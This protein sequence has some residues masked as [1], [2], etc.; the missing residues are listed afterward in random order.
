M[1]ETT[2]I[3]R[4][5]DSGTEDGF[6]IFQKTD[7]AAASFSHGYDHSSTSFKLGTGT[8]FG[9]DGTTEALLLTKAGALTTGSTTKTGTDAAGL[10]TTIHGGQSTGDEAGGSIIFRTAPAGGSGSSANSLATA[11]TIDSTKKVTLAGSLE[12]NGA[13]ADINA[14]GALTLDSSAGSI[15]MGAALADGQT[16]SLG[17][18]SAT[19]MI[20][21]PHGTAGSEKI[22]LT[23]TSGTA[24]DAISI[25]S[26]AGSIDI[27]AGGNITMDSNSFSIDAAGDA[28]NITLVTDGDAEDLTIAVTG[29][30][31]SSLVLSSTGTGADALQVTASAGGMDITSAGVMDITT[32]GGNS[33]I[34]IDPNGSG[35]L[36]LGSADNTSVTMDALALTLTSVNALTLT[37]GTATIA[38]GGTGDTT[39]SGATTVDLD[40]SGAMSLNSTGGAISIGNDDIN[41]AIN[42][43]T[44]G[45]RTINVATGAFADTVNIGNATGATAVNLT[46]GT[47]GIALASTG[48]GDITINSDDTM[49][50][51]ADGVLELNSSAG[52]ISIG[53]DA[54]AQA[55][56]VG[57]GAA[58]RTIT[59]GNDASAKVDV[60]ALIIELDSAGTIVTDSVTSTAI[61][62]GSTMSLTS[63]T[64]MTLSSGGTLAIDTGGTDAINFGTEAA[65]KTITIGNAASTLVDINAIAIDLDA[66]GA[67]TLDGALGVN[68]G[69]ETSGVAISIGHGTSEV[70]IND[71]L[72]VTG[73]LKVDGTTI[74]VNSTTVTVDDPVMT[75]G[76][77]TAVVNGAVSNSTA[78][79]LSASNA[80]ISVGNTVN[81]AGITNGTTVTAISGTSLTLSAA[82]T[83]ADTVKLVFVADDSKDRGIEF[84]YHTGTDD[85]NQGKVGFF[86]Y[87]ETASAFTFIKDATN[88]TEVFG[89][90]A[91]DV[92]FGGGTFTTMTASTSLDVTGSAGIILENDETITNSTNGTVLI[93]GILSAGTGSAP[94][95]FQS[96]GDYNL[97]LQ[98]GNSTTGTITIE[99]GADG[100]ISI[101]PNGT[102]E[103][104]ISKVDIDGGAIDGTAIGAAS[105]STGAFTTIT[106][107]TSLDVTGSAGIILQ[108]DETITNTVNG[109]VVINSTLAAG[110]GSHT[111]IFKSNGSNN[112][113][114]QTGNSTT[115][116]ITIVDGA[117]GNISI[118]PNGTGEVDI[119]KVDIDSGA[120]DGTTIGAT[121]ASTGAFTNMTASGTLAVDG[122]TT[123]GS[124]TG[125]TVSAAGV[126]NINNTTASSSSTSGAL[127]VDGGAGI[128]ADLSVGDNIR[129]ISDSAVL[130]FGIDSDTTLT[131]TDGT[132]LTLN[133][134]NK[135]CFRDNAIH[136]SSDAD[137]YMNVQADTGVNINI[138]GTDELAITSSTA[139][140]GT[141]IVIPDAGTIGS[142]S[143]TDAI[144][145]SSGG[146]VN[147]TAT[148]GLSLA[149]TA[150]T[151]TANELNIMDGDS[152][153]DTITVVSGDGVV[154]NDDGVMKQVNID[155]LK[156]YIQGG[157][158]A[159]T[160][161]SLVGHTSTTN[162]YIDGQLF[163]IDSTTIADSGT[164]SSKDF[165]VAKIEQV[166]INNTNG[167]A[168]T[169]DSG[170]SLYIANA[171]EVANNAVITNK[172]ALHVA[173]GTSKFADCTLTGTLGVTGITTL[174]EDLI[175][176]GGDITNGTT[177]NANNIFATSTGIT[178]VGG[179][180]INMGA[181]GSATTVKGTL[182][183]DEAV[184]FDTTLGVDGLSTLATVDINGGAIDGTVIGANSA[185]AGTFAAI[186]GTSLSLTEGNIT[187][188]G[189]IACD[190]IVVDGVGTG[191]D[192][193]FGG[194]TT[195]NKIS[196]TDNL[197]DALNINQGGTS[198][199]KFITTDSSE[200]IVFGKNTTFSGTTIA[201]LGTVTT[202]DINGGAID[203]TT[204]G[205]NSAAAATFSELTMASDKKL[206]TNI[207]SIKDP[208]EKV[209]NLRGVY[210]D[211][212]D[213]KKYSDKKQIGFIAQE[214]EK[215]V[216][217]LVIDNKYIKTVCY[218]QAVS[219][220]VEAIKEQNDI[221]NDL[222]D[223]VKF[224]KENYTKNTKT[225][226]KK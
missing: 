209:L 139:T 109:T 152:S 75:L 192:V 4:K 87:D 130:S 102:G 197:A 14:S 62:A 157:S 123:L 55:I 51:D 71:N 13:T 156:T 67:L 99:D 17:P 94:G 188:V 125:V 165:N 20:F 73:N 217:E 6:D 160:R 225:K 150:V 112:V 63:T 92:V 208:L 201:D 124:T 117:N 166:T 97:T 171:P 186:V 136:I 110:T 50:L 175:L 82:M 52:A 45:E 21:T 27:N 74:T 107:S 127:I 131:H 47:G 70:T 163:H 84:A 91:G 113:T 56:N 199:M 206:K 105:A 30:T 122:I 161:L 222:I 173:A 40:C 149:G 59:V 104:D 174:T 196:L 49:L 25:T 205:A 187:N 61:T 19:Q 7:G 37:D 96:N 223:E 53:N 81:G 189:S 168:Q 41:Q 214:V 1:S 216:P 103:V 181:S 111:G 34:T 24:S 57:T 42:I 8:S 155:S 135:L 172:Y 114:L 164:I 43:G 12:M 83:I 176:N 218:P 190:S 140:F 22:S 58:A 182:N 142:A 2:K 118:T 191:L 213:K 129:L 90:S 203:G 146:I 202:V 108:N 120:I 154:Y 106:A 3:V 220:L 132:G 170:A 169:Y 221:I 23:N 10:S 134:A 153:V 29:S 101:T 54:D 193:V 215:V 198:Y 77:T 167:S 80:S 5:I 64:G 35:T 143:D 144:S 195:T 116:T 128:A 180:A 115:G 95:V 69:T 212:K 224:I 126:V 89:G 44:Q 36:A 121:T 33:N 88:A 32:S 93:N 151:S 185:A 9:A 219:L 137:G 31:D 148:S 158:A 65:A 138:G 141:N 184:T 86:G 159:S 15:T 178:T 46:A 85:A 26:T 145:I 79:T 16:L 162:S 147:I 210:F 72:T 100:N 226:T 48:A 28:S 119:S 68:I 98:T 39:L 18:S 133:A 38:F 183:V 194:N 200:Q 66:A 179:G 11:M 211:W 60:N 207:K 204:I 76:G 177:G 78:V